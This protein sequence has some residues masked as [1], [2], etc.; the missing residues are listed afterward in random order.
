MDHH[1]DQNK[2]RSMPGSDINRMLR[3]VCPPCG[4]QPDFVPI[5]LE[6]IKFLRLAA[7]PEGPDFA[8]LFNLLI[9]EDMFEARSKEP[10]DP[11][12]KVITS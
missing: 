8:S 1:M 2:I 6:K 10:P 7:I 12:P 3:F 9:S 5:S 4:N 11:P